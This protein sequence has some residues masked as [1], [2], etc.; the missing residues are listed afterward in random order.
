MKAAKWLLVLLLILSFLTL[1]LAAC[2]WGDGGSP[3]GRSGEST[4][5][6]D[7]TLA[8]NLTATYGAAQ[9]H[10]QLTALAENRLVGKGQ[11]AGGSEGNP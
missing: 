11:L 5:Q 9:F 8:D 2:A 3:G 10:A 6:P 1:S 4:P 7:G